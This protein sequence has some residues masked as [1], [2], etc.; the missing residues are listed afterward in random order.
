VLRALVRVL[1]VDG[2]QVQARRN[3]WSA[4]SEDAVR[5]CGRREAAVE[6]QRALER[7]GRG[8]AAR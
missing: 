1:L 5:A 3:A 4:M 7:T 8:V 6:V 2:G